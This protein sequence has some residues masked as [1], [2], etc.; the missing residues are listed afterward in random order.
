M[1]TK[2]FVCVNKLRIFSFDY[3]P[4]VILQKNKQTTN[5]KNGKRGSEQSSINK[6]SKW[7]EIKT[8]KIHSQKK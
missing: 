4:I 8:M 6:T 7:Q 3:L 1:N 5:I 2:N